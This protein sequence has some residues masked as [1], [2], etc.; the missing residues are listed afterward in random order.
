MY[1]FI[2]CNAND[3][4]P[5][6][7]CCRPFA[8]ALLL[9]SPPVPTHYLI[10]LIMVPSYGLDAP[11]GTTVDNQA[12]QIRREFHGISG[13]NTTIMLLVITIDHST[14]AV[15]TTSR[16]LTT[17]MD[18]AN[19]SVLQSIAQKSHHLSDLRRQNP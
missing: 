5:C 9:L 17:R 1:V 18:V 3:L 13:D 16:A 8:C 14:V 7:V 4:A 11:G 12:G 2:D 19:V 10:Y 15:L 6:A